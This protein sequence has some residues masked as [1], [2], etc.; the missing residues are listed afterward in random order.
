MV[1]GFL[2][3]PLT[4]VVNA[5][6]ASWSTN[7]PN[8]SDIEVEFELADNMTQLN[9]TDR[10]MF[11]IPANHTVTAANLTLSSYWNPVVYQNTSFEGNHSSEL[12]P[13]LLGGERS[14]V[15]VTEEEVLFPAVL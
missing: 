12:L 1:I 6:E 5:D 3:I 7:A 14:A 13:E 8:I 10:T 2:T 9:V 15:Q 11:E 4:N